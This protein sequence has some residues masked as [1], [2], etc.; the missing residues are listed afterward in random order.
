MA[1]LDS[2]EVA[3][4]GRARGDSSTSTSAALLHHTNKGS[5]S[6]PQDEARLGVLQ[7]PVQLVRGIQ[8]PGAQWTGSV[9]SIALAMLES[10]QVDAVV[11]IA[12]SNAGTTSQDLKTGYI[13]GA[14]PKYQ[15][16]GLL[17]GALTSAIVIGYSLKLL[18]DA[19]T[20]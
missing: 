13:V 12:A 11:C 16:I 5:L 7:Q 10:G 14:T 17:I 8:M 19:S 6:H 18:N 15:Q 4:H 9:T 2:L 20:V 3:V 1:R